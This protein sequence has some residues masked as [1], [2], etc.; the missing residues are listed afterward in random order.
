MAEN[1]HLKDSDAGL[2]NIHNEMYALME[3]KADEQRSFA[4][5]LAEKQHVFSMTIADNFQKQFDGIKTLIES[6]F[7]DQR[8]AHGH[9]SNSPTTSIMNRTIISPRRLDFDFF[10][11]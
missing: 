1:T 6:S 8:D 9:D 2:K 5:K 4:V 11:I 10:Q 3:Q 7:K